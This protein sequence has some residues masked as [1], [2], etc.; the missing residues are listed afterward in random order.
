MR[1]RDLVAASAS[2]GALMLWLGPQQIAWGA[3]IVAV[4][5][6]PARDYTRLTIESDG[7]LTA[8]QFFV[9]DPPRLAVDIEGLDLIPGLRELVSQVRSDDRPSKPSWLRQARISTSCAASSASTAD[10]SIR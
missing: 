6:W 3:S 8:R 1:R 10:P 4:R 2:A 5:I 7:K 9:T